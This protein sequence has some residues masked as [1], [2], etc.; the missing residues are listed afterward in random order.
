MALA[1][2]FTDPLRGLGRQKARAIVCAAV[3]TGLSPNKKPDQ[4]IG[5]AFSLY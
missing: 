4:V 5:R 3:E 2:C 1:F